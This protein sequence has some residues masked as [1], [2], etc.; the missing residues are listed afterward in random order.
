MLST[1]Y[2]RWS[3]T[4]VGN[5]I[6]TAS[7]AGEHPTIESVTACQWLLMFFGKDAKRA[8][9]VKTQR[10]T[11]LK[12]GTDMRVIPS[13]ST[14]C[15]VKSNSTQAPPHR[16]CRQL[17]IIQWM[18]SESSQEAHYSKKWTWY[19]LNIWHYALSLFILIVNVSNQ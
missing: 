8:F 9:K 16:L 3:S 13:L 15:W 17:W 5:P 18:T 10:P 7:A 6:R 2:G 11:R 19:R 12:R 4:P 1:R 14:R